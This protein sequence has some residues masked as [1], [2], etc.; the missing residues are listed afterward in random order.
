MKKMLLILATVAML[1]GLSGCVYVSDHGFH[2]HSGGRHG[3]IAVPGPHH[4]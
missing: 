2:P 4:H 1:F 3:A